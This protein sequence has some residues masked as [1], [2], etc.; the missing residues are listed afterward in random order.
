MI[1]VAIAAGFLATLVMTTILRGAGELGLTRMDFALLLGT[2]VSDNR[3]KARAYGYVFHFVIGIGFALAYV[4]FFR[5][6]GDDGWVTGALIGALHAVFDGTVLV[7]VLLPLVHPR[8]ATAE[9]AA[10]DIALVEPPGFLMLNYGRAS[11]VV[12]LVA[13][14][15]YGAVIG[16]VAR[17]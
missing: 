10:N 2:T 9:T 17:A 5:I 3:R 16:L 11:F 7:N 15:A 4:A 8:I 1:G 13:H 14:V 12:A 6:T